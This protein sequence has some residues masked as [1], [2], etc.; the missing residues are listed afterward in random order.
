MRMK[1]V[2]QPAILVLLV[3]TLALAPMGCLPGG[4]ELAMAFVEEWMEDNNISPTTFVGVAN[5]G[6]RLASGST[7]DPKA[8]AALET[9]SIIRTFLEA[10]SLMD[11]GRKTD[12]ATAMEGAIKL[13]PNDW[14]Y[15]LSRSTLALKQ[16]EED[17]G[18]AVYSFAYNCNLRDKNRSATTRFYNQVITEYEVVVKGTRFPSFKA[19]TQAKV[20]GDLREAYQW[21]YDV[22]KD[23]NDGKMADLYR[24]KYDAINKKK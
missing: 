7:G 18:T 21:R 2:L 12:D 5:I 13:R 3:G 10:E 15:Q 8:D 9:A 24:A 20:Y 19:E 23:I 4:K 14:S 16:G 6:R 11:K 1:K 17:K 22:T